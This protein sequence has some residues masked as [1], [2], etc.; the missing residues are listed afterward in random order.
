MIARMRRHGC[1][2][3]T[4]VIV[5]IPHAVRILQVQAIATPEY[6]RTMIQF[7]QHDVPVADDNQRLLIFGHC[8]LLDGKTLRERLRLRNHYR[9]QLFLRLRIISCAIFGVNRSNEIDEFDHFAGV[10]ADKQNIIAIA[11]Q[12]FDLWVDS[13]GSKSVIYSSQ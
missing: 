10:G 9:F 8:H 4:F 12:R 1:D 7:Y 6:V 3:H 13:D 2:G 11:T 5:A